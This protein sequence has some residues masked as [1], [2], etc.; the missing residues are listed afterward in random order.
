MSVKINEYKNKTNNFQSQYISFPYPFEIPLSKRIFFSYKKVF[1]KDFDIKSF[2]KNKLYH[3][4]WEDFEKEVKKYDTL[5]EKILSIFMNENLRLGPKENILINKNTHLSKLNYFIE[6]KKPILFTVTQIAFKIPNPLKTTRKTPDLGELAF[7]S[8]FNDILSL[9][10]KVYPPG[11]KLIILGESYIFYNIVGINKNEADVYFKTV[12]KWIKQLD[13]QDRIILHDLKE[14]EKKI[15]NFKSEYKKNLEK[16]KKNW[17][18]GN[19]EVINEIKSVANT[20]YLSINTRK[21][22]LKKLMDIYD[23][24]KQSRDLDILRNSLYQKAVKQ[25]FP[26][27]AHHQSI[28]TSNL[29]DLLYPNNIKLSCTYSPGKLCIYPI[30]ELCKLYC[31]HGRPILLDN[32]KVKIVYEIDLRRTPNIVAF[33]INNE[34]QPFFFSQLK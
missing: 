31:Y 13:W 8:Q 18:S 19:K 30:N 33:Y 4:K 9:V 26:Y 23:E 15:E 16:L 32:K 10:E 11:A 28:V 25:S 2:V 12:K 22:S 20:L 3:L 14:L 29:A 6:R 21:Y 17:S 24:K 34:K 27:L 5:A 7:L 1:L